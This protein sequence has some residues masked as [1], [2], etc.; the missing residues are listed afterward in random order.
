MPIVVPDN[1]AKMIEDELMIF[2]ERVELELLRR[3]Q[4]IGKRAVNEAR[5]NHAYKDQTGNLTSS[6]GYAIFKDGELWHISKFNERFNSKKKK[7]IEGSLEGANYARSLASQYPQGI[8]LVVVAG[9]NYAAYVEHRGIGGM[10]G[11]ELQART[12]VEKLLVSLTKNAYRK[13]QQLS[14]RYEHYAKQIK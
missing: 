9:M 12:E 10:T 3:L 4:Y 11:A 2:N 7:S 5:R 14:R 13:E 6:I 8:T 1:L